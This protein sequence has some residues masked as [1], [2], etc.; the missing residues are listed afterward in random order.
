MTTQTQTTQSVTPIKLEPPELISPVAPE[1]TA[2]A[3]PLSP[4]VEGRVKEQLEDFVGRLLAGNP[5]SEEFHQQID[6][7]FSVGRKEISDATALSNK[8]TQQNLVGIENDPAAKSLLELRNLFDELNPARQ[9]EL[10]SARKF[11]GIPLPFGNK[12]SNYLRKYQSAGDQIDKLT[13]QL[14]E[15]KDEIQS[16]IASLNVSMQQLWGA[17]EKL[18]AAA[19]FIRSLDSRLVSEIAQIAVSDPERAKSLEQ[20]VLYYTRQNLQDIQATQALSI[21]G[22]AVMRE[23]KKTGREVMNACDRMA[24]LGRAALTVAV[25]LARAT[26][27]QMKAMEMAQASKQTIENLIAQTGVA[28]NSHVEMV[29]RFS[30]DPAVGIQTLQNMFDQTFKA[31]DAMDSYRSQALGTMAENNKMLRSQIENAQ[32]RLGLKAEQQQAPE[33]GIAL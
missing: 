22:Y 24:T 30:Q 10:F 7:A 5:K 1:Q 6:K 28:L 25:T 17:M 32:A 13:E 3:V 20:E 2:G 16:D 31:M 27:K 33:K 11:L 23:L 19:Y 14:I 29:T 12:L 26:D 8:F 18:E 9:G 15:A 21:N 4:E